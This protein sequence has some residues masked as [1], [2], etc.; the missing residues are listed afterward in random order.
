M[1]I[2]SIHSVISSSYPKT[3]L[4][5]G[6]PFCGWWWCICSFDIEKLHVCKFVI[7]SA[8]EVCSQSSWVYILPFHVSHTNTAIYS[9]IYILWFVGWEGYIYLLCIYTTIVWLQWIQSRSLICGIFFYV[10]INL[11]L[12]SIWRETILLL[13]FTMPNLQAEKIQNKKASWKF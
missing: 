5:Q 12:L 9:V 8:K 10:D 3:S 6:L 11:S 4:Y 2:C 1:C 7:L 13:E